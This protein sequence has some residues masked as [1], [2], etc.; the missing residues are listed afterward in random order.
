[1]NEALGWIWIHLGVI[2]G[3]LLGLGFL[4][5]DFLG[6]YGS[7]ERRLIRLGHIS[8]FGLGLLN[9]LFALSVLDGPP[10]GWLLTT[11]SIGLAAG[12]ATMPLA[13]GLVAWRRGLYPVFAVPVLSLLVSTSLI[14]WEMLP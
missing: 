8:F 14:A 9:L 12:A 11:A 2:S 7:P 4:K 5:P 6:G 3:A 13:C 1:M 10:V